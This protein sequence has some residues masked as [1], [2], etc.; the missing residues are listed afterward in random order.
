MRFRDAR[1][2]APPP[3]SREERPYL[4]L[5]AEGGVGPGGPNLQIQNCRLQVQSSSGMGYW[6]APLHGAEFAGIALPDLERVRKAFVSVRRSF[7]IVGGRKAIRNRRVYSRSLIEAKHAALSEDD[8]G[9]DYR[10]TIPHAKRVCAPQCRYVGESALN[11]NVERKFL[12]STFMICAGIPK[13]TKLGSH[14]MLGLPPL[15]ADQEIR[16]SKVLQT[17]W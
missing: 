8:R 13:R 4:Y 15:T 11:P 3:S 1:L 7:R 16:R 6:P 9:Q 5:R 12:R 17:I 10:P 14:P 2:R